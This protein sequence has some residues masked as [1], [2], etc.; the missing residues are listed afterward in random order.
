MGLTTMEEL[1]EKD[2]RLMAAV[3]SIDARR[4]WGVISH[5]VRR[6]FNAVAHVRRTSSGPGSVGRRSSD[7]QTGM[8]L[9]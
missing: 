5:R 1:R 2:G 6:E 3:V 9:R 8:A 4:V 7:D